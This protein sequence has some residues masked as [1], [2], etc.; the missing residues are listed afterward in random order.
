MNRRSKMPQGFTF[1][2]DSDLDDDGQ[3][4][5]EES[6]TNVSDGSF[7]Q[8]ESQLEEPKLHA[9][10]EMVWLLCMRLAIAHMPDV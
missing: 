7:V 9:L 5:L 10:Q 6:R 2:F 1:G 8:T 3:D 4:P